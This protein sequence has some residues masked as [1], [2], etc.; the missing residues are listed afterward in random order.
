MREYH[1]FEG[2]GGD[3]HLAVVEDGKCICWL[4]ADLP[5]VVQTMNDLVDGD[6]DIYDVDGREA[7]PQE[8]WDQMQHFL[9]EGTECRELDDNDIDE[10]LS[11]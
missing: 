3:Y 2:N 4:A 8:A 9:A 11:R 10:L 1:I 6:C 7:D 5:I